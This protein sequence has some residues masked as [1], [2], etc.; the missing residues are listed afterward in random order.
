VF[1]KVKNPKFYSRPTSFALISQSFSAER[2][3]FASDV[4]SFTLQLLEYTISN[5]HTIALRQKEDEKKI[6]PNL[7]NTKTTFE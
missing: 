4:I 2:E 3:S 5:E 1:L 7:N 6:Q